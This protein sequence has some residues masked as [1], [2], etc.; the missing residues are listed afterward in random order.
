MIAL[1]MYGLAKGLGLQEIKELAGEDESPPDETLSDWAN[2][3]REVA[4][5]KLNNAP[6][7]GGFNCWCGPPPPNPNCPN[8]NCPSPVCECGCHTEID[9]ALFKGCRKYNRGRLLRGN[10]GNADNG[11]WVQYAYIVYTKNKQLKVHH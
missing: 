10:H 4:L 5:E 3:I 6:P 2:Y 1:I 7:M 8:P 9:E 11:P